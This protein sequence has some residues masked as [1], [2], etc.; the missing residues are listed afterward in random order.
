MNTDAS[1]S[2]APEAASAFTIRHRRSVS[3]VRPGRSSDAG[4]ESSSACSTTVCPA[5]N[6]ELVKAF[7][8]AS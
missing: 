1:G 4:S 2:N 3:T 6:T 8:N 7:T 5:D